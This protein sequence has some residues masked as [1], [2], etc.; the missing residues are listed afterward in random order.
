MRGQG[1]VVLQRGL[2]LALCWLLAV[3][4]WPH[5][6]T[7]A[8]QPERAREHARMLVEDV[9]PRSAGSPALA[10]AERRVLAI[11]G[12]LGLAVEQVAV[13]HLETPP[14]AVAG[15]E[16][17]PAH[18]MD[19]PHD[20]TLIVRLPDSDGATEPA[21]LFMAHLDT[22]DGSPG[23]VD[24]AAAV[25]VLLELTRALL[26]T[27]SRPHPVMIAITAAE[28]PGLGGARALAASLRPDEVA[29]AVSLDLIGR[30][31]PLAQNGL[32]RLLGRGLLQRLAA[33]AKTASVAIEA[34]L[35]H[36][37]VS[38][39]L[40]QLERSDHGAFTERGIP[41]MHLFHRG[42]GHIDLAYHSADDVLAR[43]DAD[44][45]RDALAFV[46]A[47]ALDPAP[48]RPDDDAPATFVPIAGATLVRDLWLRLLELAALVVVVFALHRARR[49]EGPREG[50][51]LGALAW[52]AAVLVTWA[53]AVAIEQL[54]D[55][56]S[57]H[58][59]PWIHT[60]GRA[61]VPWL[62][63]VA[64]ALLAVAPRW[65]RDGR[66]RAA[67]PVAIVAAA[68]PG[69]ALL[70][71]GIVEMAWVPL[72]MALALAAMAFT[73]RAQRSAIFLAL[74]ML[75]AWAIV[76]PL[77]LREASYHGFLGRTVPLSI[78]LAVVF[79]PIAIAWLH[80]IVL[81]RP[82]RVVHRAAAI[83]A[84]LAILGALGGAAF[85]RP[86]CAGDDFVA[87]GLACE[88][89]AAVAPGVR[90]TP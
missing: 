64:A 19:L 2:R 44:A 46:H 37:V 24:D 81:W 41:A 47:L 9:G 84:A 61:S 58:P 70:W 76:D 25:G 6:A 7:A 90:T 18:V 66:A 49:R 77:R 87:R 13:G 10:E 73:S 4:S 43:V 39:L 68:I 54:G 16:V 71:F 31:G 33:A 62:L 82:P 28:E 14:V 11:F 27:P 56:L 22:V 29:F 48:L 60:P 65:Y 72:S 51:S 42:P 89:G 67:L 38:R 21:I 57:A 3:L 17:V 79:L 36:Q 50:R 5:V 40:P 8:P 55:R 30:P 86:A 75:P 52:I 26:E 34:P 32:S 59:Q 88:R 83:V 12:A 35:T 15:R 45:Q 78:I 23:A 69:A 74:A 20:H 53:A 85:T 63:A 1:G 80:V